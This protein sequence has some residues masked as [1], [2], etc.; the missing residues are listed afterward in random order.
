[1]NCR[2]QETEF[3]SI[4][5]DLLNGNL[6][7]IDES[8]S[9]PI[10]TNIIEDI[11]LRSTLANDYLASQLFI[12]NQ[13]EYSLP[14]IRNIELE[15]ELLTKNETF[16]STNP[17]LDFNDL[18]DYLTRCERMFTIVISHF[19][20]LDFRLDTTTII[21]CYPIQQSHHPSM[22]YPSYHPL[23]PQYYYPPPSQSSDM[24][25]YY[26]NPQTVYPNS[27][28]PY[29]QST[30][31][32]QHNN[33]QF[34]YYYNPQQSSYTYSLQPNSTNDIPSL[35]NNPSIHRTYRQTSSNIQR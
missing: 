17:F 33:E 26:Y 24:N 20:A 9:S 25:N 23:L 30:S 18:D 7:F 2:K 1:M 27:I 16:L 35:P 12:I 4:L 22:Y 32:Y 15:N 8:F 29:G 5:T 19:Y 14:L 10:L 28:Y 11:I 31:Y 21:P 3:E 34:K 13:S 6:T